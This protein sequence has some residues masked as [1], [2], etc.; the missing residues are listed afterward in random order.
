MRAF[1]S[2]LHLHSLV[3]LL[4]LGLLERVQ[5][6]IS[7]HLE[8]SSAAFLSPT[9]PST[10]SRILRATPRRHNGNSRDPQYALCMSIFDDDDTEK[11]DAPMTGFNP[12]NYNRATAG[13]G[14]EPATYASE[15]QVISL[16]KTTMTEL[17]NE[18]V[19]TDGS[20]EAMAPILKSYQTFLL[21]PLDDADAV[22]DPDSIYRGDMTREERYQAYRESMEERVE[23][24]RNPQ[25]KR[26]LTA[27]K[28]FVLSFE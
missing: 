3:A 10:T 9:A 2:F 4:L 14:A 12:F 6:R 13:S 15:R 17:V 23:K 20:P 26:V 24:A 7:F 11:D 5:S 22:L 18:L 27:M 28:D 1:T 21:E 19:N 16:R 25:G 8:S